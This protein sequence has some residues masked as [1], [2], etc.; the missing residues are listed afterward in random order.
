MIQHQAIWILLCCWVLQG[1]ALLWAHWALGSPTTQQRMSFTQLLTCNL[2][3]QELP[4]GTSLQSLSWTPACLAGFVSRP[5][6]LLYAS[7]MDALV[8]QM[9]QQQAPHCSTV[10]L[11]IAPHVVS[12]L[13]I[14]DDGVLHACR[15]QL[16]WEAF[17]AGTG[18]TDRTTYM[19]T[20]L[21]AG[22]CHSKC[23]HGQQ[24]L[25]ITFQ[26]ALYC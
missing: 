11:C 6:C 20:Y 14:L 15:C 8:R 19:F 9:W 12:R 1:C 21:D 26:R 4:G 10:W 22:A 3:T 25:A 7:S 18:P 16:F 17:P 2:R 24:G 5:V 13:P 23:C